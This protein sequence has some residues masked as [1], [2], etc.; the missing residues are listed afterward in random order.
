MNKT[1]ILISIILFSVISSC[2]TT[3]TE[4]KKTPISTIITTA[5]MTNC[6]ESL[7]NHVWYPAR[8]QVIE[9]CRAVTGI[10]ENISIRGDGDE[11]IGIKL[12]PEYT[13]LVNQKNI[14]EQYGDLVIET[15]CKNPI[16]QM[17]EFIACTKE[18]TEDSEGHIKV[19]GACVLS[20]IACNGFKQDFEV[21]AGEHIKV[22]GA[23][24]LDTEHG[25]NEIHPITSIVKIS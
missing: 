19:I 5:D 23:Y 24:V 15:I 7:W 22:T 21:Y 1:V 16:R 8:L 14:D 9:R 13:N 17:D 25:W 10:V 12:D 2:I 20:S 4:Q 18:D 3:P 11:H 6:D